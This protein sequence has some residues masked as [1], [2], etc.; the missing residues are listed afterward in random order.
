MYMKNQIIYFLIVSGI[1]F[2]FSSCTVTNRH[3]MPGYQVEWK[4]EKI[5][6]EKEAVNISSVDKVAKPDL[7]FH[8]QD[9]IAVNISEEELP[10]NI[11]DRISPYKSTSAYD[12]KLSAIVASEGDT[13]D[14]LI[15]K[16]GAE[17]QVKIIEIN[18]TIIRY[19]RCDVPDG[20]IVT[21]DKADVFIIKY[22]NGAKEVF[23]LTDSTTKVEPAVT[24]TDK[25]NVPEREA[26]ST[27]PLGVLS[28]VFSVLGFFVFGIPLGALS[29]LFGIISMSKIES[30][31]NVFSGMGFGIVAVILGAI[32]IIGAM[33]VISSL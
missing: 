12:E 8:E 26:R 9:F 11:S 29:I 23:P 4:T 7:Q 13:C 30:K 22:P 17:L 28:L 14:I 20:P 32:D 5:L 15:L 21:I 25:S 1:V 18:Q 31:P 19:K 33:L 10:A 3:F 2:S 16:T 27:E 24:T 6:N